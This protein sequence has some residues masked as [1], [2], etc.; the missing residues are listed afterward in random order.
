MAYLVEGLI[1]SIHVA[2]NDYFNPHDAQDEALSLKLELKQGD[3]KVVKE[4]HNHPAPLL[5]HVSRHTTAPAAKGALIL[6]PTPDEVVAAQPDPR[7]ARRSQGPSKEMLE[8]PRLLLPNQ[9]N[10]LRKGN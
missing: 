6:L 1:K 10:I 2:V 5:E 8:F 9:T 3:A 4:P 7:L